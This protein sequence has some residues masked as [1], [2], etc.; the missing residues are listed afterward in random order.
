MPGA[1]PEGRYVCLHFANEEIWGFKR[2]SY[3]L[4]HPGL[5]GMKMR[6]K[7]EAPRASCTCQQVDLEWG[8]RSGSPDPGWTRMAEGGSGVP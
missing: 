6:W 7:T 5:V 8:C 2:L 3:S 1:E 4:R